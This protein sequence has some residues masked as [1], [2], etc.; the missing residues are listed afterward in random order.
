MLMMIWPLPSGPRL[1]ESSAG[2]E[3]RLVPKFLAG[4]GM[5]KLL[6]ASSQGESGDPLGAAKNSVTIVPVAGDGPCTV[7]TT[8][9]EFVAAMTIT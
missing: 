2:I 5:F 7:K 6:I 8:G 3:Q 9:L 4:V 1:V